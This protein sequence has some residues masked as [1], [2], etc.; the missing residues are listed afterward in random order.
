VER[1]AVGLLGLEVEPMRECEG[2][3]ITRSDDGRI[4]IDELRL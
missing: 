3:L 4:A 2:L 1:A